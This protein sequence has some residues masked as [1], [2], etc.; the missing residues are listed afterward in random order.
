[1]KVLFYPRNSPPYP[2]FHPLG[3]PRPFKDKVSLVRRSGFL[4]FGCLE[5]TKLSVR[6]NG[7][8][9]KRKRETMKATED[10]EK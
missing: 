3:A 7:R 4:R 10:V 8:E 9:V 1:M 6:K 5:E 2:T